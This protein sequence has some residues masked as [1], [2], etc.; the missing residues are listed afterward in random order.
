M[1]NYLKHTSEKLL[2]DAGMRLRMR[3]LEADRKKLGKPIEAYTLST[4][5]T[6]TPKTVQLNMPASLNTARLARSLAAKALGKPNQ[7]ARSVVEMIFLNV[8]VLMMV[9]CFSVEETIA[10]LRERAEKREV[11]R[12]SLLT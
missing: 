2:G 12:A 3:L 1:D 4:S 5:D 7:L 11:R 8:D 6:K 9:W 10:F